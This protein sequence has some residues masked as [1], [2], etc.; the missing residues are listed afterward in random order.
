MNILRWTVIFFG[1]VFGLSF[2]W[3]LFFHP[4]PLDTP[5]TI[6][7]RALFLIASAFGFGV[8]YAAW[9]LK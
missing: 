9:R 6:F 3:C 4:L 1:V 2:L 7:G 8:A 5:G